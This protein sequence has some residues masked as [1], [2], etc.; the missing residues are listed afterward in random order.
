MP[1]FKI[2]SLAD[3][4]GK[5][6]FAD[7]DVD[8]Y[9]NKPV[10]YDLDPVGVVKAGQPIG[11]LY[12]WVTDS[13]GTILFMFEGAN[14]NYANTLG[15]YFV[16]NN[17]ADFDVQAFKQQGVLSIDEQLAAE[18]AAKA[19]ANMTFGDYAQRFFIYGLV[20]FAV[21]ALGKA[22]IQKKL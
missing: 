7:V 6:F 18:A 3:L 4:I 16:K 8:V 10:Q 12:S 22:A 9:T 1:S 19:K 2:Y 14:S 13:D 15:S 11:V 17:A 21:V 5:T 20:A